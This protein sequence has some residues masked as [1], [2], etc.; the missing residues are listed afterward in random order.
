MFQSPNIDACVCVVSTCVHVYVY[1]VV[2]TCQSVLFR[3]K[4]SRQVYS[5][6][7]GGKQDPVD[8]DVGK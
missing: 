8:F 6:Q 4:V 2:W 3:E 7:T 1:K 5:E